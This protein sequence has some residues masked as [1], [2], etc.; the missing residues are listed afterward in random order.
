[1]SGEDWEIPHQLDYNLQWNANYSLMCNRWVTPW[2]YGNKFNNEEFVASSATLPLNFYV[3][4]IC[5]ICNL[6]IKIYNIYSQ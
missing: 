5:E 6:I 3:I 2:F 1:V 4:I